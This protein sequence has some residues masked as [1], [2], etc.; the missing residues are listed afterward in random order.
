[1]AEVNVIASN[2]AHPRGGEV[3]ALMVTLMRSPKQRGRP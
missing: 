3:M 2:R 1:M